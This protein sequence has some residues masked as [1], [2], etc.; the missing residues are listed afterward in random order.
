MGARQCRH[1]D[2]CRRG[3]TWKSASSP[4]APFDDTP[5]VSLDGV[6]RNH[7]HGL[8]GILIPRDGGRV[9]EPSFSFGHRKDAPIESPP[10]AWQPCLQRTDGHWNHMAEV[11]G[12]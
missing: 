7:V 12:D 8:V 3:F 11:W 10:N 6:A 4:N 9:E 1:V 2:R 5:A